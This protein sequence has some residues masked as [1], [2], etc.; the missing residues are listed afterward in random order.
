MS[1]VKSSDGTT[2]ALDQTGDG[3]PVI[4]VGGGPTDRS[5]NTPLAELLAPQVTVFNYDRRGHGASGDTP[6][7]AVEREYDDLQAV[8]DAA[9]GSAFVFGSSGGGVIALEAAARGRAITK[10]ALWEPPYVLDD[11]TTRARPPA[12]YAAQLTELISADRRGDAVELFSTEAAAIPAEFVAQMRQAPFWAA[13]EALAHTL[14][15]DAAIMGDFS[16]PSDRLSAVPVPTLVIDGGT[17]PWLTHSAQAVA[18]TVPNAQRATLAG[19][20]H[21]VAP[22]AIAPVLAEYFS[23]AG[24]SS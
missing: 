6:P 3:P 17:T 20:P 21:N 5:V 4:I 16:M 8:I 10:L 9:G 23:G 24:S 14:V 12:D 1:T 7:Y 18:D 11:E 19:Q 22:D 13:T 2:I 15:Y